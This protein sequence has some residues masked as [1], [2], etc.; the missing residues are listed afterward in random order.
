MDETVINIHPNDGFDLGLMT[1]EHTVDI[2]VGPEHDPGS[3]EVDGFHRGTLHLKNEVRAGHIELSLKST[4]KL[5]SAKNAV[6][7]YFPSD[8]CGKLL[9]TPV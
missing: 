9:V 5:G 4:E 3:V 6:V 1:T 8:P 7:H 2:H